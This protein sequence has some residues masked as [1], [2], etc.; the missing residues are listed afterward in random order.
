MRGAVQ[1]GPNLVA[2]AAAAAAGLEGFPLNVLINEA[3]QDHEE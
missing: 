2:A 1:K 3:K